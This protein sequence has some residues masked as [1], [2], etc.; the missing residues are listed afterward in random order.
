[1]LIDLQAFEAPILSQCSSNSSGR[2]M[3]KLIGSER[4]RYGVVQRD[5][6]GGATKLAFASSGLAKPPSRGCALDV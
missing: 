3:A 2:E 1:M 5:A 4:I 6:C